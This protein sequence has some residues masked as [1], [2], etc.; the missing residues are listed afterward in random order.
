M[1]S[2]REALASESSSWP[3][4]QEMDSFP[5]DLAARG[6]VFG[7]FQADVKEARGMLV[8][9][10]LLKTAGTASVIASVEGARGRARGERRKFAS[11][12]TC[13]F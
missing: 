2:M 13:A 1:T 5:A 8:A 11:R 7:G 3:M 10:R 12:R 6:A 9:A 4:R